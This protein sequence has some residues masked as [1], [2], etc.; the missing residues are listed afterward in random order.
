MTRHLYKGVKMKKAG[1]KKTGWILLFILI[2][3]AGFLT[4]SYKDTLMHL[5]GRYF[6][7]PTV[8]VVMSTY[9]RAEI[10]PDAIESILNQTYKDFEFIIIDDGSNDHTTDVIKAYAHKDPR[11]KWIRNKKNRGLIYSLNRGL[12]AARGKYIARMDDDD[13]AVPER[14]ERQV[15]AMDMHPEIVVMGSGIAG[16]TGTITIDTESLP[17]IEDPNEMAIN[18]Y[19]SSGLAHPTIMMRRDFLK[20]HNLQYNPEYLY[21]EDCGLYMDILDKGGKLSAVKERLLRFG[22]APKEETKKPSRYGHIQYETFKAIQRKKLGKLFTPDES[23]LGSSIDQLGKCKLWQKMSEANQDKN[24]VNQETLNKMISDRCPPHLDTTIYVSH[25]YW[26]D[27]FVREGENRLYR[28]GSKEYATIIEDTPEML[29]VK[30]DKY[31]IERYRRT[32]PYHYQYISDKNNKF[33]VEK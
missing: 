10:L 12:Q 5:T 13:A 9:N 19:F 28:M 27:F 14:F 16:K 33:V 4:G 25:P 6:S 23:L 29:V 30:W 2:F 15:L 3:T 21:A 32:T 26:K 17:Q 7:R 22:V 8:S 18:T 1:M 11:I 20:K 24:I 31:G